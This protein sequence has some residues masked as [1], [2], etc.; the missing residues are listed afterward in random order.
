MADH[1]NITQD[2]AARIAHEMDPLRSAEHATDEVAG[3]VADLGIG[4]EPGKE[5]D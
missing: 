1:D 4:D 5:K 3:I 2:E